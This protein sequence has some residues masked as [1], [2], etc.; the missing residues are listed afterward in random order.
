MKKITVFGATGMTGRAIIRLALGKGM[1]V[2]A[3]ARNPGKLQGWEGE[4]RIIEAR[5][6]DD[7]EI[8]EA[9]T[10]ADAII[11]CFGP[12]PPYREFFCARATERIISAM[13]AQGVRR[14][15]CITG[16]LIGRY[17]PNRGLLYRGLRRIIM[18]SR[19]DI[20][21][22]RDRQEEIVMKSGLDWTVFKPPN[23]AEGD[24]VLS[25]KIG[26]DIHIGAFAKTTVGSLAA[27]IIKEIEE[28]RFIGKTVFIKS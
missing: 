26:T 23:L 19:P 22:D 17:Y 8:F 18:K 28:T 3:F 5:L 14:L 27:G 15:I 13:K 6:N 9:V 4:I 16:A 21:Y 7:A 2:T 11:I 25:T 1:D 24:E 10:G 12:K 20:I